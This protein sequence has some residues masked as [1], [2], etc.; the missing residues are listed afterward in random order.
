MPGSPHYRPPIGHDNP[1]PGCG[2]TKTMD[3][4][5][6]EGFKYGCCPDRPGAPTYVEGFE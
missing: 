5:R 1:C 2:S 3:E 4:L 6:S